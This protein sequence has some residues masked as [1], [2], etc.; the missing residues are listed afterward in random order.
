MLV[1]TENIKGVCA[2]VEA[3]AHLAIWNV[4]KCYAL[5][6]CGDAGKIGFALAKTRVLM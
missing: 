4:Y 2:R 5:L 1:Q 3:K 6:A